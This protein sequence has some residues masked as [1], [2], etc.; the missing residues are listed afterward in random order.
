MK[1]ETRGDAMEENR[2]FQDVDANDD[3]DDDN[4]ND[5]DTDD[6]DD[7]DNIDDGGGTNEG[8]NVGAE[9]ETHLLET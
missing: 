2:Q 6:D 7:D 3:D 5:K 4:G 9:S 1:A 8:G